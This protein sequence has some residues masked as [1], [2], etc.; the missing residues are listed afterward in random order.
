MAEEMTPIMGTN[1]TTDCSHSIMAFLDQKFYLVAICGSTVSLVSVVENLMLFYLFTTRP[2]F[3]N[4]HFFYM[5][6]LSFSDIFIAVNY[7]LLFVI[8]VLV[9]YYQSLD[10]HYFWLSYVV[11]VFAISHITMTTSAF[12]LVAASLERLFKYVF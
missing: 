4:S 9:D 6:V 12:L 3:R 2:R 10:L 11:P 5:W 8:Q 7:T 1:N